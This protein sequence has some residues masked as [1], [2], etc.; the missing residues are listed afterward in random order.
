MKIWHS[1]AHVLKA[2]LAKSRNRNTWDNQLGLRKLNARSSA[3][4][5]R[6]AEDLADVISNNPS[7]P[8]VKEQ[9]KMQKKRS[10]QRKRIIYH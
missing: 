2:S 9:L 10:K 1:N 7:R 5:N 3:H 6:D 4:R 8:I